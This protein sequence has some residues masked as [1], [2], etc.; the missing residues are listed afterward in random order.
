MGKGSFLSF[1]NFLLI[2]IAGGA[3]AY[4]LVPEAKTQ[5]DAILQQILDALK[6]G[7]GGGNGGVDCTLTPDDPSCT[8]GGGGG[9][10][11]DDPACTSECCQCKCKDRV[12]C[13]EGTCCEKCS[14]ECPAQCGGTSNTVSDLDEP[15]VEI[16][17]EGLGPLTFGGY[18]YPDEAT[19]FTEDFYPVETAVTGM[20]TVNTQ[21]VLPVPIADTT[22]HPRAG[23][24]YYKDRVRYNTG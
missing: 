20:R 11:C 10:S 5:I 22:E 23:S 14:A 9:P 18:N 21:Y 7:G 8:G 3:G 1:D 6:I 4:F 15:Y 13:P 12:N 19:F 17:P 2:A 24:R 16:D